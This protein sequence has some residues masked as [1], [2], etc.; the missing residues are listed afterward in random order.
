MEDSEKQV[1]R[2]MAAQLNEITGGTVIGDM[3][4]GWSE[5]TPEQRETAQKEQE[6]LAEEYEAER[7]R[8]DPDLRRYFF[9]PTETYDLKDLADA[10]LENPWGTH[11][12]EWRTYIPEGLRERWSELSDETRAVAYY[13]AREQ[14]DRELWD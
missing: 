9:S 1:V 8:L 10:T 4:V 2:E 6:H 5:M 14:A 12:H 11:V 7:L 3:L 13:M